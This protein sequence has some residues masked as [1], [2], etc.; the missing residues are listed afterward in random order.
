MNQ[1]TVTMPLAEWDALV[2]RVAPFAAGPRDTSTVLAAVHLYEAQGRLYAA[3]TDRYRIGM[4]VAAEDVV[5]PKGFEALIG[6][7]SIADLARISKA[8]A[9]MR[10]S[11]TINLT[12]HVEKSRVD[13]SIEAL[14][15]LGD[16]SLSVPLVEGDYPKIER[17]THQALTNRNVPAPSSFNPDFLADYRKVAGRSE[18]LNI[19]TH[20]QQPALIRIGDSFIGALVPV[21]FNGDGAEFDDT[22]WAH[23]APAVDTAGA[24]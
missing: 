16:V 23:L 4:T 10:Q 13:V 15:G 7:T 3:A 19:T 17:I 8:P 6:T 21:R 24:A 11:L 14:P 5:A 22:F 20:G 12:L 2:G 9:Q 1:P 18:P